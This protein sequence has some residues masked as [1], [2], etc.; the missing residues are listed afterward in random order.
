MAD[1]Y[2][3]D[4]QI[5]LNRAQTDIGNSVILSVL[6]VTLTTPSMSAQLLPSLGLRYSW[7]PSTETERVHPSLE[8]LT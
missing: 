2:V 5:S 1:W 8:A 4:Y 3:D 6:E 7:C